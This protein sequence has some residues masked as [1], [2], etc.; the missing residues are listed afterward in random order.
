MKSAC[1]MLVL[2]T[3]LSAAFA[4]EKKEL[5]P[6]GLNGRTMESCKDDIRKHCAKTN[7]KQECLV[8]H[9]TKISGDCQDGLATVMRGG[10]D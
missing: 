3:A 6:Q 9:W 10:G 1:A 8:A 2:L 4:Q 7:L 5:P